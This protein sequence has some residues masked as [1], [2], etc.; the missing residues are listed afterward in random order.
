VAVLLMRLVVTATIAFVTCMGLSI[1]VERV[2][3]RL[4]LFDMPSPRRVH[5]KPI[6]RLGGIAIA[7]AFVVALLS[8]VGVPDHGMLFILAGAV[9]ITVFMVI[10]DIRDIPPLPKGVAQVVAA[11]LPVAGGIVINDVS[12]PFNNPL[13]PNPIMPPIH[14]PGVLAVVLTIGWLCAMMNVV[15]WLDGIDGLAAGVVAIA[16]AV[17]AAVTLYRMPGQ[18]TIS[19]LLVALAASSAGFLPRN[20][21]PA[22]IIMGDSG[23]HFLGYMLGVLSILGGARLA[24]SALVL[25]I[26]ILD[27]AWVIL[28][29][30]ISGRNPAYF[31]LG[32]LHHRLMK[33]GLSKTAI[34]LMLYGLSAA[35][36][37]GAILLPKTAKLFGFVVLLL[38]AVVITMLLTHRDTTDA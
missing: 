10:D 7:L 9:L 6:P 8:V 37:I 14:V 26:P 19:L 31:D 1:V 32:H 36:G 2:C 18:E 23:A 28:V 25:G 12:S 21:G 33:A 22:R 24:S 15:N 5:L 16:A 20:W 27:A 4:G 3:V 38:V 13:N 17:L 29:R 35:F 11:A 30:V 34:V